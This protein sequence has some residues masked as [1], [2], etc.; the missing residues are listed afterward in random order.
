[1][2]MILGSLMLAL[3]AGVALGGAQPF[4]RLALGLGA[5]ALAA[6]IFTDPAW[7]G[8]AL[9]RAGRY[10]A[11]AE[12]FARAPDAAFNL[13]NAQARAGRYAAALEA[14]DLA[15]A[16]RSDPDAQANFDLVR[17]MYGGTGLEAD[18]ISLF[19]EEDGETTAEAETG[20]GTGRAAGT[21]DET[22]NS[23][24][25]PYMPALQS[26]AQ[27]SA[28]K[29]FD[30]RFVTADHSVAIRSVCARRSATWK[31]GVGR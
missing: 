1:M 31:L 9:Y 12:A 22:T 3:L 8:A 28:R 21:G 5:P 13:G 30:A 10:E 6:R 23:G 2:R 7:Q 15:M 26:R 25:T 11:A 24:T 18:S 17:A 16:R 19:G 14:Y 20:K 27:R 29:V 4:G